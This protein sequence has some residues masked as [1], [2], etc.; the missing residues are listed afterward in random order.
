MLSGL[1]RLRL[2]NGSPKI[3][4]PA[5]KHHRPL[6][7]TKLFSFASYQSR[8]FSKTTFRMRCRNHLSSG[9]PQSN[10]IRCNYPVFLI[11]LFIAFSTVYHCVQNKMTD[12]ML[13]AQG[14]CMWTNYPKSLTWCMTTGGDTL[15]PLMN[16]GAIYRFIIIIIIKRNI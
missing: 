3:T 11:W 9:F 5:E 13:N 1:S 14:T 7:S 15:F 8:H 16:Y 6:D 2:L 4:F 10:P 12:R